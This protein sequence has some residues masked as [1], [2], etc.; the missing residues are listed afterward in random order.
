M[1]MASRKCSLGVNIERIVLE[2]EATLKTYA[3]QES[4]TLRLVLSS[5]VSAFALG[6]YSMGATA[7]SI[8]RCDALAGALLPASKIGLP[9]RG[10]E[11][12]ETNFFEAD[13]DGA[14]LPNYCWVSGAIRPLDQTAPDI[15]FEIAMPANW[16]SRALM[17]GG[18]GFDGVIPDIAGG[19][20]AQGPDGPIE[21]PLQKGYAVFG[22]DSGHQGTN[23]D[24]PVPFVDGAFLANNE[25]LR[26]WG[27]GD[28]L[29]KTHDVAVQLI[30]QHYGRRPHRQYFLGGSNGGREGLM[31]AQRWPQ[32]FDGVVSR[33]PWVSAGTGILKFGAIARSLAV[34]G[35]H[36]NLEQSHLLYES[37]MNACDEL[38]GLEDGLIS[39]IHACQ[40]DP[41][42]LSCSTQKDTATCLSEAQLA[43]L[44]TMAETTQ[45]PYL[46]DEYNDSYPGIAVFAGVDLRSWYITPRPPMFPAVREMP[47]TSHTW[48]Q[49]VR[50]GI[51][52]DPDFD[53]RQIDPQNPGKYARRIKDLVE[54][55][56][57]QPDLRSFKDNGGKLIIYHGFAD[58]LLSYEA[59]RKYWDRL[60]AGMD[61]A[62]ANE[63]AHFYS[64]PGYGHGTG[65]FIPAWDFLDALD[66][67]VEQA[68]VPAKLIVRDAHPA[69]GGRERPLCRHG[70]WPRY[71]GGDPNVAA[72]FVCIAAEAH[73]TGRRISSEH[74]P[75]Q[76][77]GELGS[78]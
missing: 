3:Q 9:T 35:G 22:S 50:F 53:W 71:E 15:R 5:L 34:P 37:V 10:A 32:D 4:K 33:Y 64:V 40:F 24:V 43:S 47:M 18:G 65:T 61:N 8:E 45:F 41:R 19:A 59:T 69:G 42:Q 36:L 20:G 67:W 74:P 68:I 55:I 73:R 21:S 48:D 14:K 39:N 28:A 23:P 77:L 16:N 12:V 27:A 63:F 2:P 1:R 60:V 29:K 54:M 11:V 7:S 44:E 17:L 26:N 75:I 13:A 30:E 38:D 25:A 66:D 76:I 70:T 51:V 58:E 49:F 78:P 62:E 52:G 72:S 46:A 6:F 31:V 56:T 57:P